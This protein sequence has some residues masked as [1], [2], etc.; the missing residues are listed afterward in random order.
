M[1]VVFLD[2]DGV[3]IKYPKDETAFEKEFIGK[4]K[5][6][7][8]F[9]WLTKECVRNFVKFVNKTG[10]YI[11][12]SSSW[13]IFPDLVEYLTKKL[14]ENGIPKERILWTT[15]VKWFVDREIEI[16]KW[17]NERNSKCSQG[18]HI[19]KWLAIDDDTQ[20][21]KTIDA[22]WCLLHINTHRWFNSSDATKW[23][24]FFNWKL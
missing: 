2:V 12:I 21:L 20:D 9:V 7:S 17:I 18:E 5:L 16:F 15:K 3:L 19:E 11:V 8:L 1:K 6:W 4:E 23:I 14:E 22:I 10:V 13:R 24:M